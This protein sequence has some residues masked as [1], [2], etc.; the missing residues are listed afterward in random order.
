MRPWDFTLEISSKN[1]ACATSMD[2]SR[3]TWE[4][5]ENR[6]ETIDVMN[7]YDFT[8]FDRTLLGCVIMTLP[9]FYIILFGIQFI[10]V[11]NRLAYWDLDLKL[12][13]DHQVPKFG[14]IGMDFRF[15]VSTSRP[16]SCL[17]NKPIAIWN[18]GIS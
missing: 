18:Q 10:F 14:M 5:D 2:S 15:R 8:S 9:F 13:S 7:D 16:S 11:F 3:S 6:H 4:R 12:I 1:R 17:E